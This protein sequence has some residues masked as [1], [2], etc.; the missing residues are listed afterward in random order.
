MGQILSD[1]DNQEEAINFLIDALRWD[2]KNS[3]ALL[4]MGNIYSKYLEDID[5]ALLYYNQALEAKPDDYITM[6]NIGVNL[7]QTGN[8]D[9]AHYFFQKALE[10]NPTYPNAH[11]GLVIMAEKEQNW[12]LVFNNAITTLKFCQQKDSIYKNALKS[13]VNSAE[14]L[15]SSTSVS[16]TILHYK[17]QLESRC[18]KNIS[19][20]ENQNISTP[21]KIEFAEN[22]Q[23]NQHV[24]YYKPEYKAHEHLIMHELVH[25]D[26]VLDARKV[27]ANQ[28]FTTNH[29][30]KQAFLKRFKKSASKKLPAAIPLDKLNRFLDSLFDGLNARI[31]NAP[32]DLFIEEFLFKNY[33]ELRP[34]QLISQMKLIEESIN[35]VTHKEVLAMIPNEIV[36]ATK[37]YNHVMA[38]QFKDMFGIDILDSYQSNFKE[39]KQANEFY[40]EYL[41]YKDDKQA[42]EEYELVQHWADDL[43]LSD[44]FR[45][46]DESDFTN[47]SSIDDLLSNIEKDPFDVK[48]PNVSKEDSMKTFLENHTNQD[49]N[50]AVAMYMVDALNYFENM[51]HHKIK[52]MAYELAMMGTQGIHPSNQNYIIS[53]IPNKK[54]SG[55]HVLA[56]Y[57][58]SWALAM[59]EMLAQLQMPFDKEY[60][61][62]KQMTEL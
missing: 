37:I 10:L 43:N 7:F 44:F 51:P 11:M 50:S 19:I 17:G 56:Y 34:F 14:K 36:S 33:K 24:V 28:F 18:D 12:E 55:Y 62:A 23:R 57:Y 6:V 9:K 25:L 20:E 29:D 1:E 38:L 32:I 21:A 26:F 22:Y 5:T 2:S 4:M 52:E 8:K 59:P 31:Y 58:V 53:S 16:N 30:C 48:T 46:V 35:A 13:L 27:N 54:F 60:E 3:F 40:E 15:V 49:V 39:N 47:D 45:L 41:E 42:A 61:L